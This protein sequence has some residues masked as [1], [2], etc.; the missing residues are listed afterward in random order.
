[1]MFLITPLVVL[2]YVVFV[3]VLSREIGGRRFYAAALAVALTLGLGFGAKARVNLVREYS[4][5]DALT[6]LVGDAVHLQAIRALGDPSSPNAGATVPP[7]LRL[8]DLYLP[9]GVLT[10][11]LIG[12]ATSA[13]FGASRAMD[14]RRA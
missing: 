9:A 10:W 11:L 8:P 12:I 5:E 14:R 2:F 6:V 3:A 4:S 7:W 1:M 13:L